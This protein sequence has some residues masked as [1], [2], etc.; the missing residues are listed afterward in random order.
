MIVVQDFLTKWPFVF[1]VPDQ[2]THRI[3][4][5]IVEEVVPMVGADRGTNLLSHGCV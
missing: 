3:A 1:A 2:K 4:R 5:L